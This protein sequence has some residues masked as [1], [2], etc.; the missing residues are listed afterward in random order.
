MT[1]EL[2]EQPSKQFDIGRYMGIVRRRYAFFLLPLLFGWAVVWS[3]SWVLPARYKSSTLI[4][5]QQP[6]MPKNYVIPNISDDVQ[7]RLRSITQQIL[8]RTRLLFIIDSLHLYQPVRRS[9]TP[10]QKVAQMRKDI[11]ID[12]VRDPGSDTI[13][14]FRVSYSAASPEDAQR[15]TNA[16]TTLFINENQKTLQK[17]S[18]HTTEFL[19]QQLEAAGASLAEQEAKVKEFQS[20][21]QGELPS[22][23]AGNLQILA[24]LQS[25]LQNETDALTTARQQRIYFQSLIEQYRTF[26]PVTPGAPATG[27]ALMDEQIAKLK[28]QLADLSTRYTDQYPAVQQVKKQI[29]EAEQARQQAAK[30]LSQK[31][32]GASKTSG[33]QPSVPDETETTPHLLQLESQLQ[34]NQTEIA[35]REQEIKALEARVA[36]Y[37]QRLNAEPES[38]QQLSDLTRGYEQSQLN[39]NDLLKKESESAMATNME[40]MQQGERF[41]VL[42]PPSLPLKPDFP[43]RLK[44]C[45]IGV[46]VGLALALLVGGALEFLDDRLHSREEITTLLPVIVLSEVPQISSS[47]DERKKRFKTILAWTMAVLVFG[48]IIAGSAFSYLHA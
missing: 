8:S 41:T 21:H 12:L 36:T 42:D 7:D 35:N 39:Y 11:D 28:A 9:L 19:R 30:S 44:F 24:G 46:G 43:N 17:E 47:A 29:T 31:V 5:V 27:I 1:E 37:Q 15:V 25:Q 16:L 40:Q 18:E 22:Q 45:G 32:S 2:E 38:E 23:Q 33:N 20:A 10:D 48:I 14:A 4:L 34:A 6:T 13:D 3:A 26:D